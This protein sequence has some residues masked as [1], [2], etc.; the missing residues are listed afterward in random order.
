MSDWKQW[1]P[2]V[3]RLFIGIVFVLHGWDLVTGMW[4]WL[5]HGESWG[6]IQ[7][8]A[9]MPIL[10][11]VVWAVAVTILEFL[12]GIAILIGYKVRWAGFFLTLLLLVFIG[13]YYIPRGEF[14]ESR[15]YLALLGMSISLVLSGS[16]RWSIKIQK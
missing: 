12:C 1:A 5:F 16:G 7:R 15:F 8:T 4:G 3:I 9:F 13:H 2:T 6:F 14:M 11:P 10:P